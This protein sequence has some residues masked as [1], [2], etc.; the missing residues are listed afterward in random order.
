MYFQLP[1]LPE[2]TY[3]QQAGSSGVEG[4]SQPITISKK[5][6]N[7]S[8][9]RPRKRTWVQALPWF[10]TCSFGLPALGTDPILYFLFFFLMR[11]PLNTRGRKSNESLELKC[12]QLWWKLSTLNI[13]VS[14]MDL[15]LSLPIHRIQRSHQKS[16]VWFN[17]FLS[18]YNWD[19]SWKL[20]VKTCVLVVLVVRIFNDFGYL[21]RL[22][23]LEAFFILFFFC[24]FVFFTRKT[25]G[26]CN[27]SN[28]LID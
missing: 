23:L 16:P 7:P 14:I 6:K 20:P 25:C 13:E 10:S 11:R 22:N 9:E 4:T 21:L 18:F 17:G 8:S 1:Y 5:W 26:F 12:S 24:F 19:R 27:C 28:S 15:F 3:F 2:E